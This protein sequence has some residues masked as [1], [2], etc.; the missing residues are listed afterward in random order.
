MP[1]G[2]GDRVHAPRA[3]GGRRRAWLHREG[4]SRAS[5]Q[6]CLASRRV[7]HSSRALAAIKFGTEDDHRTARR[8]AAAERGRVV[9]FPRR[10]EPGFQLQL[11]AKQCVEFIGPLLV[12]STTQQYGRRV[13]DWF[14]YN[15]LN[16][17]D[18]REVCD[19]KVMAF[20]GWLT[21]RSDDKT[22]NMWTSALNNFFDLRFGCRPFNTH[23]IG[24]F[25]KKYR[26]AVVARTMRRLPPGAKQPKEARVGMPQLGFAIVGQRAKTAPA[27]RRGVELARA[28]LQFVLTLFMLRPATVWGFE[29]GDVYIDW[30]GMLLVIIVRV[31]KR[32]PELLLAPARREVPIP[33]DVNHPRR[34]LIDVMQLAAEH[35]TQWYRQL[36]RTATKA[37]AASTMGKWMLETFTPAVHQRLG[38]VG[39]Y[40]V[41]PYSWRI[42]AV[43]VCHGLKISDEWITEWGYWHTKL[44]F[45]TYVQG[46]R[47]DDKRPPYG[48]PLFVGRLFDFAFNQQAGRPFDFAAATAA[49]R[50][51]DT[52][53]GDIGQGARS[54][55]GATLGQSRAGLTAASPQLR[56]TGARRL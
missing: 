52:A 25:K 6:L 51:G 19:D 34:R 38:L 1:D 35:D 53:T 29:D 11:G 14:R 2:Y 48:R 41:S 39:G 50:G 3:G 44:Q 32:W 15:L 47:K 30:S 43:S 20:G 49:E 54:R 13:D 17:N 46:G 33:A 10:D 40:K 4:H 26:Q 55:R 42:A 22:F 21:E 24:K 23:T 16:G 56:L 36:A 7:L 8:L 28:G 5:T 9:D 45:L 37:T 18:W 12:D 27:A 31:C